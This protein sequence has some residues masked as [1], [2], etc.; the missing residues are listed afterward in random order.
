M[1]HIDGS[2]FLCYTGNE[3]RVVEMLWVNDHYMHLT[4]C[5]ANDTNRGRG[6]L[7]LAR[8][9]YKPDPPLFVCKIKVLI[10]NSDVQVRLNVINVLF[11]FTYIHD[12]I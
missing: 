1:K 6:C 7:F 11:G 5:V 12:N 9:N 8:F 10:R 4:Q 2:M 3:T